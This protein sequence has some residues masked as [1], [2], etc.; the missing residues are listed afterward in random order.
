MLTVVLIRSSSGP[1]EDKGLELTYM[2]SGSATGEVS[3]LKDN[4]D[5]Q[6]LIDCFTTS[7]EAAGNN[8]FQDRDCI[9]SMRKAAK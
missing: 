6:E 9:E 5:L 7:T 2:S 3:E 4:M 1:I 8:R